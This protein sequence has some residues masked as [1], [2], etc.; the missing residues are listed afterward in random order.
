M[1][2]HGILLVFFLSLMELQATAF[3]ASS[4]AL[5]PLLLSREAPQQGGLTGREQRPSLLTPA[6]LPLMLH[7]P[8]SLLLKV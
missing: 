6:V 1:A 2:Q 3:A 8:F 5:P 7:F 4:L